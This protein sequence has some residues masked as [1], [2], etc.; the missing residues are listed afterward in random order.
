M[1]DNDHGRK[2]FDQNQQY[3]QLNVNRLAVDSHNDASNT[4]SL[5]IM[6]QNEL[7]PQTMNYR[8]GI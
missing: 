7:V 1:A 6:K 8:L 4:S 3:R 2:F 5:L